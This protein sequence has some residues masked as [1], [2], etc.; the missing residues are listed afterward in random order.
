MR[1]FDALGVEVALQPEGA[2]T[3]IKQFSNRLV[4]QSPMVTHS[5]RELHM[6]RRKLVEESF[7]DRNMAYLQVPPNQLSCRGAI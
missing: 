6:S 5:A 4:N 1:A 3:I 2:N 7:T